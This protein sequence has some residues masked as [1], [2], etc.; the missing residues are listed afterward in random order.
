MHLKFAILGAI[1]SFI[2]V[3]GFLRT[4]Q[5]SNTNYVKLFF[6]STEAPP[7]TPSKSSSSWDGKSIPEDNPE[8]GELKVDASFDRRDTRPLDFIDNDQANPPGQWWTPYLPSKQE[9]EA[10][11][12]GFDFNDGE[13]WLKDKAEGKIEN[14]NPEKVPTEFKYKFSFFHNDM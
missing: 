2:A 1:M 6:A 10:A 11:E 7:T 12:K 4:P 9:Q 13:Q 5:Q 14:V 3:Q 8:R